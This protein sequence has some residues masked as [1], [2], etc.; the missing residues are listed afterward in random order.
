MRISVELPRV[1][2][3][4][5][6]WGNWGAKLSTGEV[7]QLVEG[8]LEAGITAF[9]HADIYGDHT[10]EEA[11]GRVLAQAPHLRKH[12]ML[13]SKC[14][15]KLV[16][17]NRPTHQLKSYDSSRAHIVASAEASLSALRTDRLDVLL[18]HRPDMLLDPDEVAEAFRELQQAGKVSAFG[19]SNF[20]PAQYALLR[21]RWPQLLT[22]QIELSLQKLDCLTDGTLDQAQQ[23]NARPMV[24]SPLGGGAIFSS[25][26]PQPSLSAK[27]D[28]LAEQYNTSPD[29]IAYAWVH[30]HP[31]QPCVVTGSSKLERIVRAKE[32]LDIELS[33]EE[34]YSLLEA[35]RGVE[36][37]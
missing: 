36:V 14:G 6:R 29:T 31:T 8:C 16:T 2:A 37:A 12:M 33:R 22:N 27:L 35:S 24:W 7:Q 5:M 17:P 21:D 28:A 23:L 30:R 1:A 10:E 3:G 15:I 11:F 20:T 32:A 34:W 25:D 18:I 19:V 4:V 26:S 9:D 13:I